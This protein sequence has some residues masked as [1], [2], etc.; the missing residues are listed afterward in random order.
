MVFKRKCDQKRS[1]FR[2]HRNYREGF[3]LVRGDFECTS[4][5]INCRVQLSLIRDGLER[6]LSA[7]KL[8][9]AVESDK[10]HFWYGLI[11]TISSAHP[12][13]G[14]FILG[15][16]QIIWEGVCWLPG[17]KNNH[18]DFNNEVNSEEKPINQ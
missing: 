17:I 9:S 5:H 3:S 4:V 16:K 11:T 12:R 14:N 18:P 8:F 6:T 13:Q 1:S 10:R 2:A 7:Q 15:R